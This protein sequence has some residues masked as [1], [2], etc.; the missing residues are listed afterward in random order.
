MARS[1]GLLVYRPNKIISIGLW[2]S[3][4]IICISN[5]DL[6]EILHNYVLGGCNRQGYRG[7]EK[8]KWWWI[9]EGQGVPGYSYYLIILLSRCGETQVMMGGSFLMRVRGSQGCRRSGLRLRLGAALLGRAWISWGW[10]SSYDKW[11][12]LPRLVTKPTEQSWFWTSPPSWKWSPTRCAPFSG[13]SRDFSGHFIH[14][15]SENLREDLFREYE[16]SDW[17]K[18]ISN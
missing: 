17:G 11:H 14:S 16:L 18:Y 10:T 7:V 5:P 1:W 9:E 4:F 2:L 13:Q 12:L 8:L 15:W 3:V 6:R